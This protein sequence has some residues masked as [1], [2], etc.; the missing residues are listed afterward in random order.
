M[1]PDVTAAVPGI[2]PICR[3]DLE[4][5]VSAGA[6]PPTVGRSVFQTYDFVRRRGFGPDVHA[7]AWVE[8]D[9]AVTAV[10]YNDELSAMTPETRGAF[11]PSA[12]PSASVEVRLA[13][14]PAEAWDSSTSRV[15]FRVVTTGPP[16]APDGIGWVR[17]AA[18]REVVVVP[19]SAVLEADDSP[20]VLVA[21]PNG[22]TLGKRPIEVGRVFGGMAVVVSGLHLQER[23]LVRSAFFLDA[24]RRMRREEALELAP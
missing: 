20:Y 1:H 24:E 18:K 3:M 13:P 7:P 2:C 5:V 6:S 10:L 9:G 23:V 22:R 11:S 17:L 14:E 19:S 16:P 4:P 15:H 21:S 8:R 12:T